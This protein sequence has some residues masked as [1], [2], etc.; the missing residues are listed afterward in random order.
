MS[1]PQHR[2]SR[3]DLEELVAIYCSEIHPEYEVAADPMDRPYPTGQW[4]DDNG[5]G[6][7]RSALRRKHDRTVK[8]FLVDDVGIEPETHEVTID[9]WVRDEETTQALEAYFRPRERRDLLADSTVAS[10]KSRMKR[11]VRAYRR[12]HSHDRL[13]KAASDPA[14]EATERQR[15]REVLRDVAETYDTDSSRL[16][17]LSSIRSVYSWLLD[18]RYI[19]FNPLRGA[20]S[21][22][23]WSRET[24]DNPALTAADVR[25]LYQAASTPRQHL[26]IVGLAGWGLRISELAGLQR[27]QLVLEGDDPHVAFT[28]RKNGP[29]T[30]AMLYGRRVVEDRIA[31]LSDPT[32]NGH[33]FPSPQSASGHRVP[34]TLRRWFEDLATEAGVQVHG[35]SPSPKMGRRFWYQQYSEAVSELMEELSAIAGDQGSASET[36]V[37]ESYNDEA[38]RRQLRRDAMREKLAAAF[39]GLDT[40]TV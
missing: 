20:E 1:E 15:C 4:L 27:S 33:L 5:Y 34:G 23:A 17:F 8:E 37:W 2:W 36:V 9:S 11:W 39:E 38:T 21:E 3:K 35:E 18:E 13:I 22:F 32:W 26:L 14:Q 25:A 16:T 19:E 10:K 6:G 24:P 40:A 12:L 31:E 29:G 30:V 28:T 7:L